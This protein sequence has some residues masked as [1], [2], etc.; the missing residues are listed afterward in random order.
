MNRVFADFNATSPL[1]AGAQ[2]G[3]AKAIELW[4]NPS[5]SHWDGR[6][7]SEIISKSRD[8]VAQ[9]AGVSPLEVVFTSGGSEA[10]TL[11]LMGTYFLGPSRLRL[12]TSAVEHS[13]IRDTARLLENL[14]VPVDYLPVQ[15]NGVFSLETFKQHVD[16]FRPTLVSIMAANNETGVIFPIREISRF[17]RERGITIHTDAVQSFGKLDSESWNDCDLI[18]ITAHKIGGPKGIGALLVRRGTQLVAT[19][20]GGTQEIKRRGGTENTLGILGFGGACTDFPNQQDRMRIRELRDYFEKQLL[21]TL[22]EVTLNGADVERIPNTTSIRFSGIPSEVLLGAL[23]L[24]GVSV[25]AGSACS[26]GSLAPSHVL[27]AMGLSRTEAKECL[28]ISWG[29]TTSRD[30]VDRVLEVV[31]RHVNRIRERRRQ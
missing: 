1:S 30:D 18:S 17:C 25:S 2:T 10:N 12:L 31:I 21:E 19:H 13:S 6:Q 29:K 11:A 27:L 16:E 4:G 7:A 28:R 20:Y 5:S 3:M 22:S 24:E 14:G 23:D 9:K 15:K 8:L 26:S